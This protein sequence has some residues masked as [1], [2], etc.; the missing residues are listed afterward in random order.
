VKKTALFIISCLFVIS[1]SLCQ[2]SIGLPAIKNYKNIDYHAGTEIWDIGQDKTGLLYFANN[3]GLLTFDGSYWKI[4]P[5]PN[6]AAIKSIAIDPSGK[7]YVG[8]QDELG[9][10][11]PDER[12]ILTYHSFRG[13]IPKK[14]GQ[15]ADIWNIVIKDNQVFFRSNEIILRLKDNK[16]TIYNAPGGWRLLE[17]AGQALFAEDKTDGLLIF[18]DEQW[19][20]ACPGTPTVPLHVKSILDYKKDTLLVTTQKNGLYLLHGSTLTKKPTAIDPILFNDLTNCVRKIDTNKYAIGTTQNGVLII[21]NTGKLIQQFSNREGLQSTNT[22]GLVLDADKNLWLGLEN[23]IAFINYNTAVTH[24]YPEQANQTTSSALRIFDHRLYIG[25]A[26]GLYN[27][28]LD[29]SQKDL[30]TGKGIF[31]EVGNTKGQ[32][33]SLSEINHQLLLGHQ[34][35]AFVIKNDRAIPLMTRHGV[36][37][38]TTFPDSEDIIAGTYTGLQLLSYANGDF[39]NEGK[40]DSFYESLGNLVID[41]NKEIWATHP[42]R[43]IF[44]IQLSADRRTIAHYTQY[45]KKDGLPSSLNNT[46]YFIRH[47]IE[48]ASEKGIYEYDPKAE[49]FI[50]SSFFTPLFKDST[51]EYLT[52]DSSGNIWFVNHQHVG[53]IDFHQSSGRSPFTLTYFPELASQTIRGFK[54]IVPYNNE[55]IFLGSDNGV[56]HLNYTQYL[57]SDFKLKVLL[58]TVKAIAERD[59]LIFG[60]YYLNGQEISPVQ[61]PTKIISLPN[62]WNSFHF[63]YSSTLYAQKSNVEFSY[64]LIGFDKGWSG[65]SARTEKDYT[66]L[67]YGTYTFSVVA[68][69]N[70]GNSSQPVNYSF[71]VEPAWYQTLWAWLFY[72]LIFIGILNLVIKW[73]QKRFFL[74]QKRNE[75]EQRRL[76]YLH[77][78]ELDRT[79][80][81]IIALQKD[82]LEGEL[83]FKTKELATVTMHLVKRGGI[84]LGIK[85]ELLALIK[86]LNI[87]DP[88]TQFR[89]VFKMFTDIEK[90]DDEWNQFAIYFDQVHNN[91]ISILKA[92]FP[93]LSA[94]DLKLCAYLRLNLSSKEIAQLLNISLKGVEI[95]RYRVRKKL[96]ISSEINLY[97]F[98]IEVTR[99]AGPPP[100][101]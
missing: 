42:Y 76:S 61:D 13:I 88:A 57:K 93:G 55:N 68:R 75:E 77:S 84:V 32:V 37:L 87:P 19:Q 7:I 50:P 1:S 47:R 27:I 85:Q 8:G 79:E 65:W 5:M 3:D 25:T 69:N 58:S 54:Y 63:E 16:I 31:T 89:S 40:I 29:G 2:S 101:H 20:P 38:F 100:A 97:D 24:I 33:W 46:V 48:I 86:K 64:Q 28:P 17:K 51:I 34:E 15:F 35:G 11:F 12:G 66:N 30:S 71:V 43:G 9:Y 74:Q 21:D 91:F 59:S 73:Q 60:G 52:E 41:T 18:N 90:N 39:K 98:L 4:Y 70:L 99:P 10:F 83:E 14:E 80:K 94:T 6:K 45:T 22:L 72:L 53:V 82:K 67:P 44:K 23:G 95:S 81:E 92:K 78:L 96:G 49:K 62:H 56:F 26:N 36:W